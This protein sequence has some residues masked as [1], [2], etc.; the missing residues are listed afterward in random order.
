ML[1]QIN[2][3]PELNKVSFITMYDNSG[4][5]ISYEFRK[6]I[7]RSKLRAISIA[8]YSPMFFSKKN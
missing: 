4:V 8:Y 6:I 7:K 5:Y 2:N 1:D 3:D